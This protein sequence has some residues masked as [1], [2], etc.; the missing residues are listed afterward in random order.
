[1]LSQLACEYPGTG[2]GFLLLLVWLC[3]RFS[4]IFYMARKPAFI[5]HSFSDYRCIN[6]YLGWR[7]LFQGELRLSEN[8][9]PDFL[10]SPP[11][12]SNDQ[13]K[14]ETKKPSQTLAK[15]NWG[16]SPDMCWSAICHKCQVTFKFSTRFQDT[17]KNSNH[18]L[19][20]M[21]LWKV[22]CRWE[23]VKIPSIQGSR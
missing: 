6:K 1:M 14:R 3:N 4:T 11:V 19:G 23:L 16:R 22:C 9:K 7:S 21:T 8:V 2:Q 13:V 12:R 15:E 5:S 17:C 10:S 20:P 18:E